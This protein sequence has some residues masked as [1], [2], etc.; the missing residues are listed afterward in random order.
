MN[1]SNRQRQTL[2]AYLGAL[3]FVATTLLMSMGIHTIPFVGSLFSAI[4]VY[5]LIIT[6]F[7]AGSN[8]GQQLGFSGK[9][10]FKLQVITNIQAVCLWLAYVW[11]GNSWFLLVLITSFLV[12]LWLD[13]QLKQAQL[14]EAAYWQTRLKVTIIVVLSLV[15]I[16]LVKT[17]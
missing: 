16:G 8:W 1:L 9:W 4:S 10:R 13:Q 14:I 17:S 7:M 3:P 2:L 11:L 5:A 15:I 12:S 6:S